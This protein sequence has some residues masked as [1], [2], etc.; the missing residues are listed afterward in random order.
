MVD[1]CSLVYFGGSHVLHTHPGFCKPETIFNQI[2]ALDEAFDVY[3]KRID[4]KI[5]LHP[6]EDDRYYRKY[7]KNF[8][9]FVIIDGK[10]DSLDVFSD[11]IKGRSVFVSWV[12]TTIVEAILHRI[13]I[14]QLKLSDDGFLGKTD[15][16]LLGCG[17]TADSVSMF[18]FYIDKI[19]NYNYDDE[20]MRYN[21]LIHG[22]KLL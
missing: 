14:I 22:C 10:V 20:R 3:N 18:L 5:K 13:P 17:F 9:D 7:L 2:D 4:F 1:K 15:Y 16:S 21:Q 19:L 6:F 12:S 11:M 8:D